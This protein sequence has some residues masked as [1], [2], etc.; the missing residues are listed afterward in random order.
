MTQAIAFIIEDDSQLGQIF[1]LALSQNFDIEL[2]PDGIMAMKR[3]SE[4]IPDLV[5]LD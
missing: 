4:N 2:I 3:L 5:V 1:S